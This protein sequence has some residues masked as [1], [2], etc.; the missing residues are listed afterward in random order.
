MADLPVPDRE[1]MRA[2]A[3]SLGDR[4][5]AMAEEGRVAEV[6]ALWEQA[7]AALP[8]EAARA[9]LTLAYAWYQALHGEAEHGVRL[10]AGLRECPV[11]QVRGQI[12]VLVRNRVRIEPEVVERTW[13]AVTGT[14]LPEWALLAD[15][16]I[17]CVAYWISAASREESR[18]LYDSQV[19][20]LPSQTIDLVLEELALGDPRVRSAIAVHRALL[21]LGEDAGTESPSR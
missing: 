14:E 19:R 12:R 11:S 20:R 6:P 18:A 17:D 7:I 8:D 2:V 3:A 1:A 13:R 9:Q 15:E 4:A 21:A 10:A 5:N 16:D